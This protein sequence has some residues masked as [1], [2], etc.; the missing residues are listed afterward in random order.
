MKEKKLPKLAKGYVQ[1]EQSARNLKNQVKLGK[2][3]D[4]NQVATVTIIV[5]RRGDTTAVKSLE[6]FQGQKLTERGTLS[7]EDF[8]IPMAPPRKISIR[9]LNFPRLAG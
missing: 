9:W 6:D 1:V 2:L 3:S 8:R 4:E 5:K 7:H